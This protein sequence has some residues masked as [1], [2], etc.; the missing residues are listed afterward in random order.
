MKDVTAKYF[1]MIHSFEC[2]FSLALDSYSQFSLS[3]LQDLISIHNDINL[4]NDIKLLQE[5][6]FNL[7]HE[8]I[9]IFEI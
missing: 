2:D 8:K 3:Y 4:L 9:K 1:D 5:L 6:S 7:R